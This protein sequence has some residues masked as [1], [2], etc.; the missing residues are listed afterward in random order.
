MADGGAHTGS[1]QWFDRLD[2]FCREQRVHCVWVT[3]LVFGRSGQIQQKSYRD[4]TLYFVTI[5]GST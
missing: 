5:V 3:D 1:A 2:A 4:L